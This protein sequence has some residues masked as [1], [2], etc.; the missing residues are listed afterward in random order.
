MKKRLN[1]Q[2]KTR[3]NRKKQ[4]SKLKSINLKLDTK[5]GHQDKERTTETYGKQEITQPLTCYACDSQ[6]NQIKD[7]NTNRNI[8]VRYSRDDTMDVH[9]LQNYNGG[10][11]SNNRN[12]QMQVMESRKVYNK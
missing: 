9:E 7:C 4:Y 11:K 1:P 12:Q 5:I 8:F 3:Q 6:E 10:T 2:K